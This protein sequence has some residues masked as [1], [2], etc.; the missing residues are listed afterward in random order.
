MPENV[1]GFHKKGDDAIFSPGVENRDANHHTMRDTA[2]RA[3]NYPAQHIHSTLSQTTPFLLAF[4]SGKIFPCGS[5]VVA[6]SFRPTTFNLKNPFFDRSG[7]SPCFDSDWPSS[8]HP[9]TYEPIT[10]T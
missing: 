3:E 9:L 1:S 4:F 6:N 10:V 7:R 5:N 2:P 8:D